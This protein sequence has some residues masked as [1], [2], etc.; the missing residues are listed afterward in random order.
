[1]PP[2][3]LTVLLQLLNNAHFHLFC[4]SLRPGFVPVCPTTALT[5]QLP[6]EYAH[7]VSKLHQQLQQSNNLTVTADG[8]T[9]RVRRAILGLMVIFPNGRKALLRALDHFADHHTGKAGRHQPVR[10]N[11]SSC[12]VLFTCHW[13]VIL[14]PVLQSILQSTAQSLHVRAGC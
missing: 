1:M 12:C 8:W 6:A 11:H 3:L 9:D 5:S 7:C 14:S 10:Q 4:G 2:V 13:F